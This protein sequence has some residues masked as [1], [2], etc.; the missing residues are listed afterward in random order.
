MTAMPSLARNA[1]R[2]DWIT[3]AAVNR[4]LFSKTFLPGTPH[5]SIQPTSYLNNHTS[6]S[7]LEEKLVR[8]GICMYFMGKKVVE[9]GGE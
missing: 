5:I 1:L 3:T 4:A 8:V 2:G 7:C 9:K 6:I